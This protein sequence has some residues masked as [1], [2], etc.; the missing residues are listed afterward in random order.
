MNERKLAHSNSAK[1]NRVSPKKQGRSKNAL[2]SNGRRRAITLDVL[3]I[4]SQNSDPTFLFDHASDLSC[5]ILE[6]S[7][8]V[9]DGHTDRQTDRRL[10]RNDSPFA[11][12]SVSPKMTA[13]K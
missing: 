7:T 3:R 6:H 2:I 11:I 1:R 13:Q 10:S 12:H 8:F 9:S 5:E 4:R